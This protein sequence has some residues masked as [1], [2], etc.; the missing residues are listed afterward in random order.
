MFKMPIINQ[1]V[2]AGRTTKEPELKHTSAGV[3][4]S[5][6]DIAVDNW[7]LSAG[8]WKK[9]TCFFTVVAWGYVAENFAKRA[10]KGAPVVITGRLSVSKWTDQQGAERSSVEI[11]AEKI[12]VMEWKEAA[13][14]TQ[15]TQ[16]SEGGDVP[17]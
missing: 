12:S 5:K 14:Q 10:Y 15:Q 16:Y 4:Y 1:V 17:F 11:V 2:I 6:F 8:E 13:E 3:S 7:R 9:D